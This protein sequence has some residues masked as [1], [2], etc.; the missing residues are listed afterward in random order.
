M[1]WRRIRG[2]LVV[3]TTWALAWGALGSAFS[4]AEL[5]W[6]LRPNPVFRNFIFDVL[7]DAF[8]FWAIY[9][10]LSGAVFAVL[11][12]RLERRRSVDDLATARVAA[13]GALG[14]ASLPLLAIAIGALTGNIP[15][16]WLSAPLIS[17]VLGA[18]C[19]AASL[20]FAKRPLRVD[21]VSH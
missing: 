5:W 7:P 11:L 4:G 2:T 8:V 18:M 3:A 9:G 21:A 12:A 17:A 14:G 10:F 20:R 1:I 13:W 6:A 16:D 15:G 19:A